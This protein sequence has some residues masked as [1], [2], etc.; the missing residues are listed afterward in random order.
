MVSSCAP[1]TLLPSPSHPRLTPPPPP[2]AANLTKDST[3][4]TDAGI[5]RE[6]PAGDQGDGPWS[7]GR[8]GTGN[9]GTPA[10]GTPVAGRSPA[11]HP[12][13][14]HGAVPPGGEKLAGP[15]TDV[16]DRDFVPET[17]VRHAPENYHVGRG[18]EGN[19]R[20][21]GAREEPE[22]VHEGAA[23]RLKQKIF[24]KPGKP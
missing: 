23:E 12:S 9:I 8:G 5:T 3:P 22:H 7:S 6:G 10:K 24:G 15:V 4:Y 18:G 21:D 16:G 17:N 1:H 20:H 13:G 2:G 11:V 14:A 19:A